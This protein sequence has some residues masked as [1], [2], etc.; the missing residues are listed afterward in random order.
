MQLVSDNRDRPNASAQRHSY[1]GKPAARRPT[2]AAAWSPTSASRGSACA[3]TRRCSRPPRA[4]RQLSAWLCNRPRPE[5]LT[6]P[7]API[8]SWARRWPDDETSRHR[9]ANGGDVRFTPEATGRGPCP[10]SRNTGS[11][12][13]AV[14]GQVKR[15]RTSSDA[16]GIDDAPRR[17]AA[18]SRRFRALEQAPRAQGG[19]C[20]FT[21]RSDKR[22]DPAQLPPRRL[23]IRR[24]DAAVRRAWRDDGLSSIS[25]AA[26]APA[27]ISA[28][29][30]RNMCLAEI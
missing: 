5:R 13:P 28:R 8:G 6:S 30:S 19:R 14:R 18:C 26:R 20:C 15:R 25:R 27:V 11:A 3:T 4:A 23:V 29:R 17:S 9:E 10:V 24:G 7:T 1:R 12:P 21:C 22:G 2:K 16:C